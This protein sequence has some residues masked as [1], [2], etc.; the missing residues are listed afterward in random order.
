MSET[1]WGRPPPQEVVDAKRSARMA[2][3]DAL[4]PD[5]RALVHD[6]G[7]TVVYTLQSLGITKAKHIRHVVETV[8]N[9]FS[10]TRGSYSSQGIRKDVDTG[11]PMNGATQ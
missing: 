8:L 10:P 9:E 4:P 11:R 5:V 2:A 7:Y 3:I 6:Y 1:D